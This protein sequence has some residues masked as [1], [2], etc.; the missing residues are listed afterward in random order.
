M[1]PPVAKKNSHSIE[2]HGHVRNDPYFWLNQRDD[3]EVHSYLKQENQYAEHIMSTASKLEREIFEELKGRLKSSDHS[4]PVKKGHFFYY[5]KQQEGFEHP[6]FCRKTN[7]EAKEQL[8][9]NANDLAVNHKFFRLNDVKVSPD[10]EKLAY[11]VDTMGRNIFSLHVID[12]KSQKYLMKVVSDMAGQVEWSADSEAVFYTAHDT[13]TLRP[14]ILMQKHI[15]SDEASSLYHEKDD[16][17]RLEIKVS[18]SNRYLFVS[19]TSSESTEIRV[20]N[21]EKAETSLKLFA[22][23]ETNHKYYIEHNGDGFFIRS[24]KDARNFRIYCN[25]EDQFGHHHWVEWWPDNPDILIEQMDVFSDYLILKET[26]L[27]LTHIRVIDRHTKSDHLIDMEEETW[28]ASL[29]QNVDFHSHKL[30]Y[31]FESMH[32]PKSL[33]EYDLGSRSKKTL[34]EQ[35]IPSGYDK[36]QYTSKRIFTT[37]RDGTKVP[38]SLVY[39]K[40]TPLDGTAPLLLNAYGA[41]GYSMLA[42]FDANRISLLNRGFIYGIAHVRGGSEL[43][44]RWYT[45]GK[46]LN[47]KNSF[48]D[49]IDVSKDL[50][51]KN[52]TSHDRLFAH[53]GSAGGLLVGAVLNIAPDLYRGAVAEVPFVDIL[54]TM[55]DTSIPLT[56]LEY[57][58][59]GNP[60]I[61]KYY[62]YILSYSPI[63]NVK[64]Q[65]YPHLLVTAGFHDPYVQY[66]EPAKWVAKLRSLKTNDTRLLLKTNFDAG[67]E[68]S[69]GRFQ[70]LK[71]FATT[72]AFLISIADGIVEDDPMN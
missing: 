72:W 63:D 56:T 4:T 32:I 67:H 7:L 18:K 60:G 11:T 14:C 69:S 55:S 9:L 65:N 6:I 2:M 37:A 35:E 57:D 54:T 59:W 20:C 44:E 23:R 71:I 62:D 30:R 64:A 27:G 34:Q 51:T 61:K 10:G 24:N 29:T 58:E 17:S 22:K 66:W 33:I 40:G 36:S 52:F 28:T 12:I 49:Y 45:D 31:I 1:K 43:G 19:S 13:Q 46:L 15:I 47:K 70:Q 41:Y 53:G 38:V 50:V 21:L 39:K 26:K 16:S 68:G 42:W 48:H 8:Y 5:V 3:P 25:P